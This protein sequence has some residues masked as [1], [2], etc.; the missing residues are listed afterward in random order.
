MKL[1]EDWKRIL[2]KAWSIK[3]IILAGLLSGMEIALPLFSDA[4]P[5]GL[6]AGLSFLSTMGAFIARIV[7]QP[8]GIPND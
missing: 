8:K 5:Q 1:I 6:F 3:L 7:A 4:L 2:I